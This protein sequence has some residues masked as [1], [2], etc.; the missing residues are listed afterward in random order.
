[1]KEDPKFRFAF[2]GIDKSE[3]PNKLR[4]IIVE[5]GWLPE[6]V[7]YDADRIEFR[8]CSNGECEVKLHKVEGTTLEE[9]SEKFFSDL[10]RDE[11]VKYVKVVLNDNTA[12]IVYNNVDKYPRYQTI[13]VAEMKD[14]DEVVIMYRS[15]QS[16]A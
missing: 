3:L 6:N 9:Q 11:S 4:R 1:M 2:R 16:G 5:N 7:S 12:K 15:W 10:L 13:D 8:V 14:G